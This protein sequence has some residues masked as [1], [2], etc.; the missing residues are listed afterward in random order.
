MDRG[1]MGPYLIDGTS[2]SHAELVSHCRKILDDPEIPGWFR[3]IFTFIEQFLDPV[4]GLILQ[5]TSGTTGDPKKVILNREAMAASAR[6]TLSFFKLR[7]GDRV[8]FCLPVDYIAGK[9]MVV[10][11]LV[12]GL[13]L[14]PAEPSGR[15]LA[16][17][18]GEF[19]FSAMVPLQVNE[20]LQAGDYLGR[21]ETL[22]IGGGELHPSLRQKLAEM[23]PPA[24]F[25]SFA[26]T[27]TYTHFALRQINGQEPGPGFRVLDGVEIG[28]DRRGC[29]VV[30]VPGIT[31]GAVITNDLVDIS[32]GGD[33]FQ[34]LGRIDNVIKTGGI[35]VIPELLEKRISAL[36]GKECLVL[37]L[38]DEKLGQRMVL[39]VEDPDPNP[40][41]DQWISQL[42]E[43]LPAHE[44]PRQVI[45][46]PE[47]PRNASFKPD[48][49][50]ALASL[51]I[52]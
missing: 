21:I 7:P 29:L 40:P 37:P 33:G 38:P 6:K 34:W 18:A 35:K 47:I 51:R 39:L 49:I 44:V 3:Q 31:D 32:E 48:R 14:V 24:I 25:E 9:M 2:F 23:S 5:R 19:V 4:S 13:D 36:L 41:A 16:G 50:K 17:T 1:T 52:G 28:T 8:L 30:D 27:E 11:A 22:L 12:G 20:S 43:Q 45:A 42:K 26:M 15:P 46:V 10:R